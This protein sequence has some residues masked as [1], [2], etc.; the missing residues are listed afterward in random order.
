VVQ[1][2]VKGGT[3]LSIKNKVSWQTFFRLFVVTCANK[4]GKTAAEVA[5]PN[6]RKYIGQLCTATTKNEYDK[7]PHQLNGA[8]AAEVTAPEGN[9]VESAVLSTWLQDI[10][11]PSL[12][13]GLL[14][15]GL[16]KAAIALYESKEEL[17]DEL[18]KSGFPDI[19]IAQAGTLFRAS[20]K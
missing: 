13:A 14:K 20:R 8:D 10:G 11:L 3:D 16:A 9:T 19:T 1:L 17:Y 2:L 7:P 5:G 18:R 15:A 4:V 6:A 12:H